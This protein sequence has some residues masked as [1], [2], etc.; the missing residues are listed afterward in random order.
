MTLNFIFRSLNQSFVFR[1]VKS[2]NV[3][4]RVFIC[5]CYI[6]T[7]LPMMYRFRL[8]SNNNNNLVVYSK[9][10]GKTVYGV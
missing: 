9:L 6:S 1:Y 8:V 10:G 3:N 5:I 7:Q 4:L 2:I